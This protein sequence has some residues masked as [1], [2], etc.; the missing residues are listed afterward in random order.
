MSTTV[1]GPGYNCLQYRHLYC[2]VAPAG[3]TTTLG[4]LTISVPTP[5]YTS[6]TIT[7]NASATDTANTVTAIQIYL[8][9]VLIF[10]SAS[11]PPITPISYTISGLQ[12]SHTIVTQA[13]NNVGAVAKVTTNVTFGPNCA[14]VSNILLDERFYIPASP[15]LTHV[16][17]A[18]FDPDLFNG[19]HQFFPSLQ[20]RLQGANP[21]LW[22]FWNMLTVNWEVT[23]S[24]GGTIPTYPCTATTIA[25]GAWHHLQLYAQFNQTTNQYI[26]QTFVYDGVTVF[27]NLNNPYPAGNLASSPFMNVENQCDL[28]ATAGTC[29]IYYDDMSVTYW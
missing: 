5:T 9:N 14:T 20:C 3:G 15:G 25:A 22:Y 27:H 29:T 4:T 7:I 24:S 12:F 21:G 19:A 17:A 28:D 23:N 1:T 6:S 8:D 26:Y 10:N 11:S 13:F 16:Q 18:E 2:A